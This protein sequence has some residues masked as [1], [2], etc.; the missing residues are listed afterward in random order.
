MKI[1]YHHRIAS[2]DGQYVHVE[3]LVSALRKLEHEVVVLGP[4]LMKGQKFGGESGWVNRLKLSMPSALYELAELAYS[5]LD[6][7]RLA[8]AIRAY[9]PDVVYERYNLYFLSGLWARHRF[10]LPWLVEVNAPLFDERS[11]YGGLRLKRL[12]RWSECAV[13]READHLFTVSNVLAQRIQV[14][15]IPD[16]RISVIRNAICPERFASLPPREEAKR[17][18]GLGERL[19]MGFTGF[20]REWHGLERV[21]EVLHTRSVPGHFILLGDGP[22]RLGIERRARDA[23]LDAHITITGVVEHEHIPEFV[24]AFDIALQPDVVPYASPLKLFEYMAAG[25]AIVAP[26]QPNIREI[27]THNVDA[28]LFDTDDSASFREAVSRLAGDTEL[29]RRLGTAARQRIADE[30]LTWNGNAERVMAR[31]QVLME[32]KRDGAKIVSERVP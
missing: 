23:G 32:T 6:Y 19:V 28:L 5:V 9:Q 8:A 26:D 7:L 11:R 18:L 16:E 20:A 3:E 1:L 15:G 10:R 29:R 21:I 27:L 13:W 14:A 2:K 17:R 22:A 4:R 31:V 24:N 25:C 12:A 30:H